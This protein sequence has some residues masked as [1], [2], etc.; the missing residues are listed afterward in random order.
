MKRDP[1]TGHFLPSSP[2]KA[3]LRTAASSVGRIFRGNPSVSLSGAEFAA[4][5]RYAV[6]EGRTWKASL[7]RDWMNGTLQY[8]FG[9][10]DGARLQG[11]RRFGPRWLEGFSLARANPL[12]RRR[13]RD[14]KAAPKHRTERRR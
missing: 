14:R 2:R 9:W 3:A 12:K 4:L 8:R 5:R 6:V 11:L 13:V 1:N 7:R 10:D